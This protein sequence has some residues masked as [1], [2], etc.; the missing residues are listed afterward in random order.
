MNVLMGIGNILNGDDGIGPWVAQHFCQENWKTI[1]CGTAPENFT[2][3]VKKLSP[4]LLVLVDATDMNLSPGE[5]RRIPPDMINALHLSTHALPLSLLMAHLQDTIKKIILVGIQP[6]R[7][8]GPLSCEVHTAGK[9]L[10]HIL[11]Q[12]TMS[13]IKSL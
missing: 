9:Y 12:N 8:N 5:I 4:D 10:I 2:G 11:T 1:D 6:K 7:F 3:K 13:T